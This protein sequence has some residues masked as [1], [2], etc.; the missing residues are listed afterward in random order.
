MGYSATDI[1]T[2]LFRV[3]KSAESHEFVKL[4]FLRVG[5]HTCAVSLAFITMSGS[6]C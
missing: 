4:E 2:T 6:S 1:I 5:E 3:T